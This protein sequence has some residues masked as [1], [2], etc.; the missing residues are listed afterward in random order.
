MVVLEINNSTSQIKGLTSIPFNKLR[1]VLSYQADAQASYFA[2]NGF[3]RIRY[4]IDK[5]GVFNTGLLPRVIRWL[6]ESK[7]EYDKAD[8]RVL[9]LMNMKMVN[10]KANFT[11][12]PYKAQLAAVEAMRKAHRG[13]I[14]MPTGSGKSLVIAL[15]IDLFSVRTLIVVPSLELKAQLIESLK[16]IFKDMSNIAVENIDST[17]LKSL[18]GFDFLIIDE[19]HRSA[20][21]T[22]QKLNKT[23][24][25]G[26]YHRAYMT[27]TP[28]RNQTEETL[29]LEGII[30]E[31]VYS[32]SYKEAVAE[33]FIVPIEAYFIEM[34][35]V[36]T[37][38][39]TWA[40]T[41]SELVVNNVA[42][43]ETIAW[44]LLSLNAQNKS[45]LC[46]VKE[47][48]HGELLSEL[49]G[50]PFSNGQD[51]DSRKFIGEFSKGK[52][53]T[54]IATEAIAGEGCDTKA[55]EFV[56]IAGLG[57]AKS[58]L[59]QKIGRCLRVFA[60]KSTGKVILILDRSHKF[61]LRHWKEQCKVLKDQYNVTP[62]KLEL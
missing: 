34:P 22:F 19:A 61:T 41:Y 39:F 14:S 55:C 30:G 17:A 54:L 37:D 62:T 24:W 49:T 1:K 27:A 57:K 15:L 16:G 56:I 13:C 8:K 20:A 6:D 42:R 29:L 47:I 2:G 21:K 3:N 35:K 45:T 44:L 59:M 10:C 18:K 9:S 52:I 36:K 28:F 33:K 11:L 48:K 25:N 23:A 60:G 32:L 43:N 4:C 46:L 31:V 38:A 53:K 51:D 58:A 50:L 26:I 40:Q 5:Q 12:K 7:I